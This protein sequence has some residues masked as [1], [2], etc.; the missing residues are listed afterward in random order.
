MTSG[1]YFADISDSLFEFQQNKYLC[2][3]VIVVN[4]RQIE[5]HS[6]V[7]AA[8]SP[9]LKSVIDVDVAMA[10]GSRHCINLPDI[11]ADIMES[12]IRFIYTGRLVLKRT[13]SKS[14]DLTRLFVAM[15]E[16]GVKRKHLNGCSLSFLRH[17]VWCKLKMIATFQCT[18]SL[19]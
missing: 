11:D 7:L 6:V 4:G 8:A 13:R 3:T 16:L 18:C 12:I 9:V 1:D 14:E 19:T 15:E 2:D 5:A 17:V 10:R